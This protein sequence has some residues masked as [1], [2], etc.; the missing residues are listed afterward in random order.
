MI[1]A[2]HKIIVKYT[3]NFDN[4]KSH[5]TKYNNLL[6]LDFRDYLNTISYIL[7]TSYISTCKSMVAAAL[8]STV[9]KL[10][11]PNLVE[12]NRHC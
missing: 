1:K 10:M 4:K 6:T 5:I 11:A 2:F 7:K 12:S 8:F 3:L 9:M